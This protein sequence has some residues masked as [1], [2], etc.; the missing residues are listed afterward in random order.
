MNRIGSCARWLRQA[1]S[2]PEWLL[3]AS[4]YLSVRAVSRTGWPGWSLPLDLLAGLSFFVL[5]KLLDETMDYDQDRA[6]GRD[7]FLLRGEVGL[8]ELRALLVVIVAVQ[9]ACTLR[10]GA[11]APALVWIALLACAWLLA[12]PVLAARPLLYSLLHYLLLPGFAWWQFALASGGCHVYTSHVLLMAVF[13]GGA[14]QYE[15]SR[16]LEPAGGYRHVLGLGTGCLLIV[17]FS[18][19]ASLAA[20]VLSLLLSGRWWGVAMA[21]G[22]FGLVLSVH[23]RLALRP[24]APFNRLAAQASGVSLLGLNLTIAAAALA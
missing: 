10:A 2:W 15:L 16:K 17:C 13:Y 7:S 22:L 14:M 23:A 20:A 1:F 5:L 8:G 18:L 3:F 9:G 24:S 12:H 6:A 4:M 11:A 19:L 21:A